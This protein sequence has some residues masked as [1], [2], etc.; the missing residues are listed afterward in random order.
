MTISYTGTLSESAKALLEDGVPPAAMTEDEDAAAETEL[1]AAE[2]EDICMPPLAF[3]ATDISVLETLGAN[4]ANGA[5]ETFEAPVRAGARETADTF[6]VVS[7]RVAL[8]F[9][10]ESIMCIT[11]FSTKIFGTKTS[12][13]LTKNTPLFSTTLTRP[14]LIDVKTCP[15]DKSVVYSIPLII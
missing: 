13:V 6:G 5:T 1:A 7:A 4:E 9:K 8:G 11:P 2:A 10:T 15:F 14:P 3:A 12:A